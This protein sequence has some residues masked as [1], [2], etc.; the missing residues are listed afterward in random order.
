[1]SEEAEFD[2]PGRKKKA[3]KAR[4]GI[5]EIMRECEEQPRNKKNK[6]S[7]ANEAPSERIATKEFFLLKQY[8]QDEEGLLSQVEVSSL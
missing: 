3:P 5:D 6:K 8:I 2:N 1:M 4:K 7:Q